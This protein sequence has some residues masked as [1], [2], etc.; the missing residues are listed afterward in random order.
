MKK[1]KMMFLEALDAQLNKVQPAN[2]NE[3]ELSIIH[4]SPLNSVIKTRVLVD[5]K[6]N[7][8]LCQTVVF[9][10]VFTYLPMFTYNLYTLQN[11]KSTITSGYFQYCS[12]F[13]TIFADSFSS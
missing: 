5:R 13:S 11:M 3:C 2:N 12:I 9:E 8:N 6:L 7:L 10:I 1:I 4:I